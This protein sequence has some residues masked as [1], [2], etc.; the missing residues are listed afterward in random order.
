MDETHASQQTGNAVAHQVHCQ[1]VDDEPVEQIEVGAGRLDARDD[2]IRREATIS[3]TAMHELLERHQV[4]RVRAHADH[5]RRFGIHARAHRRGMAYGTVQ[6]HP[7]QAHVT[8]LRHADRQIPARLVDHADRSEPV[9]GQ[10]VCADLGQH[11]PDPVWEA[12]IALTAGRS[13]FEVFDRVVVDHGFVTQK[14]L[15]QCQGGN[16]DEDQRRPHQDAAPVT[17]GCRGTVVHGAV[18]GNASTGRQAAAQGVVR[19]VQRLRGRRQRHTGVAGDAGQRLAQFLQQPI[20]PLS[21]ARALQTA[22][23]VW[24]HRR[25]GSLRRRQI[26]HAKPVLDAF[27][28]MRERAPCLSGATCEKVGRKRFIGAVT[29]TTDLEERRQQWIVRRFSDLCHPRWR[30]TAVVGTAPIPGRDAKF[31]EQR[32]HQRCAKE[33]PL[34]KQCTRLPCSALD[35]VREEHGFMPS[36]DLDGRLAIATGVPAQCQPGKCIGIGETWPQR[37]LRILQR[38]MQYPRTVCTATDRQRTE[39]RIGDPHATHA[40]AQ[41]I[42]C[43]IALYQS[44]QLDIR[45]LTDH[46]DAFIPVCRR[47]NGIAVGTQEVLTSATVPVADRYAAGPQ[48]R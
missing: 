41:R 6:K 42:A 31:T 13:V 1:W 7:I 45:S 46:L 39:L 48:R 21:Q 36:L 27:G 33:W 28:T 18:L 8:A 10:V 11:P 5:Q 40:A 44:T 16:H 9:A 47:A 34:F 15:R 14:T 23:M 24:R 20:H 30:N 29:G 3:D 4:E 19:F 26:P 35:G 12:E 25:L 37:R 2:L 22:C 43:G 32:W 38:D 17:L